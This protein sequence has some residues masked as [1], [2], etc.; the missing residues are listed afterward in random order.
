MNRI[1]KQL[2][3]VVLLQAFGKATG[4]AFLSWFCND[5][6]TYLFCNWPQIVF[7]F[8]WKQ[9]YSN[10]LFS[11]IYFPNLVFWFNLLSLK[12]AYFVWFVFVLQHF[13]RK[14]CLRI[15]G[16]RMCGA[17]WNRFVESIGGINFLSK[18]LLID[19]TVSPL[20]AQFSLILVC[21]CLNS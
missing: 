7:Q 10:G 11:T 5:S 3:A 12:F 16:L 1:A 6:D 2:K 9:S 13:T 4:W 18:H 17:R 15:S 8:Y 21:I 19:S 20:W 14:H